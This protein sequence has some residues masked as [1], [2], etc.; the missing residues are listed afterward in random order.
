MTDIH[1]RILRMIAKR[2]QR[3]LDDHDVADHAERPAPTG[4]R[5]DLEKAA[6]RSKD[7]VATA[8]ARRR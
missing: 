1:L 5:R 4:H 2:R 8:Q 3:D 6:G 7:N